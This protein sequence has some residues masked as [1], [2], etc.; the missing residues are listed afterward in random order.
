MSAEKR[1]GDAFERDVVRVFNEYGFPHAERALGLGRHDDRGD[2]A[3]VPGFLIEAK[4]CARL[5]L[6]TWVDEAVRE[7]IANGVRAGELLVPVV[8]VKRRGKPAD[9]AYAVMP[10]QPFVRLIRDR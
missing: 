10:L 7:V 9:Y 1:K 6:A 2:V 4:N 8:V 5:E 3:G